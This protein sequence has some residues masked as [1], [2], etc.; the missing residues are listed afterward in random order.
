MPDCG[1]T[2]A[3]PNVSRYHAEIH[4]TDGGEGRYEIADLGSTN[5]TRINGIP[6][7]APQALRNGDQITLGATTIRFDQG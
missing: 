6:V 7:T 2:L 3:D 4:P 5:G 1:L